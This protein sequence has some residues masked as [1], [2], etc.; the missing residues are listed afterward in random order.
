MKNLLIAVL[1]IAHLPQAFAQ[2]KP[3]EDIRVAINLN[4]VQDDKVLVEVYPP[5][6][7]TAEVTYYIPKIIPGTYS[8]D[9]YG[10]FV[11]FFKAFDKDGKEL[12]V[13][14]LDVNSWKIIPGKNVAK[15]SYLV[16]DTFDCEGSHS[17]FSPAG[18]NIAAD[19]F[20]LNLHGFVGYFT[21]LQ[22]SAYKLTISHPETLWGATS[23]TDSDPSTTQ[24]VFSYSRYFEVVDNPIMYAKPDYASFTVDGMEILLSVYAPNKTVSAKDLS[25]DIERMMRAQKKFLGDINQ[26]S[27]YAILLYL[28]SMQ[29]D[30]SGFGALEHHSCTT[31]VFPEMMPK[32]QLISGMIDVVSHEFFHTVTPLNIHSKEIHFFDY[33]S[34]K[35]SQHLWMYEGVTEYFANLFQ[36]NQGLINE[37][38]FYMRLA[39]KIENSLRMNDKMPFTK[40][41]RNVLEEPY[42][43]QY[44][45]VYE[46]GTLIAMCLDII[47]RE[48]SSGQRGILDLM[49]KLSLEY[50]AKKPF[51]DAELFSKI[52]TLTYPEVGAFLNTYVAGESPIPYADYLAKMGVINA[53]KKVPENVFLKGQTP[54]ITIKPGTKSIMVIKDQEL[55]TFM[56]NIK[57]LPGDVIYEINNTSYN[58]D[59]IYDLIMTSQN[60]KEGDAI[61]VKISRNGNEMILNGKVAVDY[62]EIEGW[63]STER[64]EE[65]RNAW[66]K[67]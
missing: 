52:I 27:K 66:L 67:G 54:Y 18:T 44:L 45:N 42:K 9:D 49:K 1:F 23:K 32:D 57:L 48:K 38:D 59:N 2:R 19:N 55:N 21:D 37:D 16:N 15:I 20:M 24:D 60:W 62:S 41:S 53:K 51:D 61:S 3:V 64:S 11:E 39:Q 6:I 4:A 5:A 10:K 35:M 28:S 13:T 63:T 40:M 30:A 43:S 26:N 12:K 25:A 31:V 14:A 58:L 7:T 22:E 17:I 33:N 65:L 36:V 8:N 34:P 46:K 50:G 29:N 47:I 56:N